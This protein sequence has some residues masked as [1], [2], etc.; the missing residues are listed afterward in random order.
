MSK[1]NSPQAKQQRR[2]QKPV[3][4]SETRE[5]VGTN[6]EDYIRVA[7]TGSDDIQCLAVEIAGLTHYIHTTTAVYLYNTL[8]DKL[9][10]WDTGAKAEGHPGLLRHGQPIKEYVSK[11][12]AFALQNGVPERMEAR[13]EPSPSR[14]V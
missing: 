1:K 13:K 6:P 5:A 12:N 8:R 14:R 3:R 4:I 7:V 11:W 2:E 9:E 10:E